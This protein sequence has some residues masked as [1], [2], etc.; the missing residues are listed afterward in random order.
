MRRIFMSVSNTH[1]DFLRHLRT[2][3]HFTQQQIANRLGI[4]RQAYAYYERTDSVPDLNS[5]I[6]LSQ[7]YHIS[8]DIF[9]EQYPFLKDSAAGLLAESP[10]SA[11]H[12]SS[13]LYSEFLTFYAIPENRSKYHH[14]NRFE[15]KLFFL[16]QKLTIEEKKELLSF[17]YF[18]AMPFL[19]QNPFLKDE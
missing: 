12:S 18:K 8:P 13:S 17:A 6:Q 1:G 5:L 7:L 15:K 10:G 14:L 19:R 9:L 4:T 2:Q 3:H 11:Y 16:I